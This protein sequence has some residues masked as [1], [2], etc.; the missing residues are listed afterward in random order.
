M[1]WLCTDDG[2]IRLDQNQTLATLRV[3]WVN[4][5]DDKIFGD[6]VTITK[7]RRGEYAKLAFQ[8]LKNAGGDMHNRELL[9]EMAHHLTL[10]EE[11]LHL[12]DDG[13]PR[14]DVQVRF[15]STGWTKA[16][17]IRKKSGRWYL[18]PEGEELLTLSPG[19]IEAKIN[20]K[21]REWR[22][23]RDEE[24]ALEPDGRVEVKPSLIL[25]DAEDRAQNEIQEFV[26]AMGPYEF[27][28]LIAALLRG[29]GY[30]TPFV[31]PKG[32]DGGTDVLAYLDP[33]GAKTPHIRVQVKHRQDK[34]SNAEVASLQGN[35][36][37]DREI[38][39]FV[40]SG[41]FTKEAERQMQRGQVHMEL[42]DLDQFIE[43]WTEHYPKLDDED[44][45]RLPLRVVHFIAPSAIS[46]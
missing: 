14:W 44:R 43:L 38:G 45:A 34:A 26:R 12:Y 3:E 6:L 24:T 22:S 35:I 31:A 18:T 25:E 32:P 21:Y 27:Q 13:R 37:P 17:F 20:E 11:E 10:T 28:D 40:S 29:M 30:V 7:V 4:F 23:A 36:K 8:L 46:I 16:G 42:I 19:E 33:L 5:N 39:L 15:S 2:V 41:G 9:E 1:V